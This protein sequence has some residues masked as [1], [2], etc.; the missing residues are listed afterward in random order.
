MSSSSETSSPSLRIAPPQS[1][2]LQ[3]VGSCTIVSRGRWA[4]NARGARRNGST[5]FSGGSWVDSAAGSGGV[6]VAGETSSNAGALCKS[7][8]ASCNCA[9]V[10]SSRSDERPNCQRFSRAISV[11]NLAINASRSSEQSLQCFDVIRQRSGRAD[12]AFNIGYESRLREE[13]LCRICRVKHARL[14]RPHTPVARCVSGD[15]NRCLQA[16]STAGQQ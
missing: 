2:Q 1:G 7:S 11:I 3:L 8:S 9:S 13:N 6:V 14:L 15:A 5:R 10:V 16:T 12:H 4:G